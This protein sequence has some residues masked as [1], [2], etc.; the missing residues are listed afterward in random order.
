MLLVSGV[1]AS[2]GFAQAQQQL[3]TGVVR[4]CGRIVTSR[5]ERIPAAEAWVTDAEGHELARTVADGEGLFQLPRLPLNAHWLHARA[6]GRCDGRLPIAPPMLVR[7]V[8][9]ALEDGDPLRGVLTLADGTPAANAALVL[10]PAERLGAPFD[11]FVATTTDAAGC[12][13]VPAAPLRA[14]ALRAYLP[15]RPLLEL[16]IAADQRVANGS[17]AAGP[18]PL[19]R[20]I[21]EPLPPGIVVTLTSDV[22][23][24]WI[25]GAMRWPAAACTATCDAAGTALLPWLPVAHELRVSAPGF[26]ARPANVRCTP[27]DQRAVSFTLVRPQAATPVPRTELRGRLVDDRGAALAGIKLVAR[28]GDSYATVTTGGDGTFTGTLP[29]G[30]G[31]LYALALHD[32]SWR[33]GD[34]ALLQKDG[35]WWLLLRAGGNELSLYAVPAASLRGTL[36]Q[37]D[38]VPGTDRSALRVHGAS[39]ASGRIELGGLPGGRYR[40]TART[41]AWWGATELRLDAGRSATIGDLDF[42]ATGAITGTL[43]D[44]GGRG[45]PGVSILAT[46]PRGPMA[47]EVQ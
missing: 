47:D 25:S 29:V 28:V 18:A 27:G 43:L 31:G 13:S 21:V 1:L 33:L 5:H 30:A 22:S 41:D 23:S 42:L 8:T 40:L 26:T 15:Q 11:W 2:A 10:E 37:P 9:L 36:L 6:P 45:L 44:A 34:R 19:R 38:G 39:D 32:P 46:G 3:T 14:R 4:L 12:W 7:A 20:V 17:F 24:P 16:L 35:W